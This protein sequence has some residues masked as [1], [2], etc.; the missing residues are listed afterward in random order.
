MKTSEY[1][2]GFEEQVINALANL[3]SDVS[4][5]KTDVSG[6]KDDVNGLKTDVSGL[7]TDVSSLKD[8][9]RRL[10]VLHEET[11]SKIEQILEI[12]TPYNNETIKLREHQSEQDYKILFHDR[13][14]G[15][16]E[17]KIA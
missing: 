11:D 4:G 7:K 9:V 13:R 14:I 2:P 10:E 3:Q 8:D 1:N 15:I 5:L 17:K 6:L 12:V 16:L